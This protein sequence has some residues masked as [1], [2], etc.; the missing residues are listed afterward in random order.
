MADFNSYRDQYR[1]ME[2]SGTSS[3][4]V[5]FINQVYGWMCG[6]L[7]LTALA[8][9]A[10]VA[11]PELQKMVLGSQGVFLFLILIE[12]GLVI[13]ISWGINKMSSVAAATCFVIY[14]IINGLTLSVILFAYTQASVALTFMV[15]AG[16]FGGMSL[17]G[18]LT[19]RDL[20]SWGNIL[21]MG[22]FGIIIASLVNFFMRSNAMTWI[23]TYMGIAIFMGLTAYD[24]QKIK[25]MSMQL[26]GSSDRESIRKLALLGALTLYL[27][28]I[29]LFLFLLRIFGNRR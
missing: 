17:Y 28:F 12:L 13:A 9:Y 27:D 2:A 19:K 23:I 7:L 20:T 16:T 8:A 29:N 10:V 5:S 1:Q 24:S 26:E 11:T 4:T 3:I 15:T 25:N 22:L 14:S 18:Y 21:L 6:G